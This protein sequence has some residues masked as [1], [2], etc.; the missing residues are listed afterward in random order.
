[1]K[2][3]GGHWMCFLCGALVCIL[4]LLGTL[5]TYHYL[6]VQVWEDPSDDDLWEQ[7]S[8]SP[9]SG[10]DVGRDRN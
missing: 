9:F 8:P 3:R 5:L 2:C 10:F 7:V 4:V 6:S 1:M